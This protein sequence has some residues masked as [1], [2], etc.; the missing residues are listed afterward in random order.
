MGKMVK[1]A[2]MTLLLVTDN[3]MFKL[4]FHG[5]HAIST[6]WTHV[7]LGRTA[8]NQEISNQ[9]KSPPKGGLFGYQKR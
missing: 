7:A 4:P 8:C 1:L 2:S 5:H 9:P 6:E 3:R